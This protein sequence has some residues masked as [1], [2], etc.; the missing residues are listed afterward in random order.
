[1]TEYVKKVRE[2]LDVTINQTNVDR[3]VGTGSL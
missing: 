1:M 2:Q 3:V